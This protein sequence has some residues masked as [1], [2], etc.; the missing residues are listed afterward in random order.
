MARSTKMGAE[1]TRD[2]L[3]STA[4]TLFETKGYAETS[5]ADISAAAGTTKGALFHHFSNKEALFREVWQDLQEEMDQKARKNAKAARSRTDP[6]AAFL[7]GCRV[8]LDYT[9]RAD[10]QKIV[11]I[12][13]PSVL[14][15]PGWYES[16]H[17]IGGQ[18]VRA[19]MR[20]IAKKGIISRDRVE[21]LAVMLRS[22]LNGA[23]FSISRGTP[24]ITADSVFDAFERL[25]RNLR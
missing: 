16:D 5:V 20:W 4:K 13:G 9:T 11:L 2:R 1:Q 25:V 24:G 10:Y 19:G 22:A 21:P 17:Y 14:G 3:L 23:G 12:D 18:N 7:A 15:E 6:Y 8:Y